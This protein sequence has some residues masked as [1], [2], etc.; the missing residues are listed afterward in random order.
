M[1]LSVVRTRLEVMKPVWE[2]DVGDPRLGAWP[3]S[4][5]PMHPF[6]FPVSCVNPEGR[7][8]GD[9]GVFYDV[10]ET[11]VEILAIVEK[12]QAQ[13]WLDEEGTPS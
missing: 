13:A 4:R 5:G 1:G 9:I 3:A 12:H 10:I 7:S 11:A 2:R 6:S 8:V